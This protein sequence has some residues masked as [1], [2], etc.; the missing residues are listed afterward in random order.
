MHRRAVLCYYI[1][2]AQ[3]F[4]TTTTTS[5]ALA[6][7]ALRKAIHNRLYCVATL[8]PSS[9]HKSWKTARCNSPSACL[10]N[11]FAYISARGTR[12]GRECRPRWLPTT[13]TTATPR[14]PIAR[15][16]TTKIIM[17]SSPTIR[18]P[19]TSSS[20]QYPRTRRPSRKAHI[21]WA[22]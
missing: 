11:Q 18:I 4:S 15:R 9:R 5:L 22:A 13:I 14:S 20:H 17:A 2:L 7:E 8:V 16:H 3:C 19:R 12:P 21:L 1:G 6:Y 10:R